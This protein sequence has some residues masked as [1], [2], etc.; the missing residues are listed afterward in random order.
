MPTRW[1]TTTFKMHV[2][3][4]LLQVITVWFIYF[5]ALYSVA[6]QGFRESR[7]IQNVVRGT[8]VHMDTESYQSRW[9][10]KSFFCFV[11]TTS[12]FL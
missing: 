10:T 11:F 5:S 3:S 12:D 2:C 9:A 6:Q 7:R 1:L 8:G 4:F